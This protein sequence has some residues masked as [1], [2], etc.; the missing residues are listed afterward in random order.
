MRKPARFSPTSERTLAAH[1]A[2]RTGK[3]SHSPIKM[4]SSSPRPPRRLLGRIG[5][6]CTYP[7]SVLPVGASSL[8]GFFARRPA[9]RTRR[10]PSFGTTTSIRRYCTPLTTLRGSRCSAAR[11]SRSLRPLQRRL[12]RMARNTRFVSS[13][14]PKRL[15][16]LSAANPLSRA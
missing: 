8:A 5:S 2:S 16:P 15:Q 11:S 3:R 7:A 14:C 9:R 12:T 10:R 13:C 4:R 6:S 1:S